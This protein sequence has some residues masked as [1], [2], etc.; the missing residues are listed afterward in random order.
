[1]F[2]NFGRKAWERG[3]SKDAPDLIAQVFHSSRV[4]DGLAEEDILA[5]VT[6]KFRGTDYR[7]LTEHWKMARR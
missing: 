5:E 7:T 4:W 2:F 6:E 3:V 1:M